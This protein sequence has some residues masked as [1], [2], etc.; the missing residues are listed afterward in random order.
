MNKAAT[1]KTD[2]LK[3]SRHMILEKGLSAFSM[4]DVAF[5]CGVAV[6]SVYNYFPSKAD[7]LSAAIESVWEE[8][9]EPLNNV[10]SFDSFADC[11]SCIY[12]TIK[13]GDACYPGF[14]TLHSLKFASEEKEKGKKMMEQYFCH[15]KDKMLV[16]L[17]SDKNV[18]DNVFNKTLSR[19]QFIDYIFS[20]LISILLKKQDDCTPLLD[21]IKNCIYTI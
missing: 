11:V 4:R 9:F 15:L 16:S 1:T 6:G 18:R 3:I 13:K 2:I 21:M 20:L 5:Q 17:Q 14:F 8:I 7:L 19:E 12:E 10:S